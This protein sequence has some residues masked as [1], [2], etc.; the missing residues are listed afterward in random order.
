MACCE[1]DTDTTNLSDASLLERY[2]RRILF[3]VTDYDTPRPPDDTHV[4]YTTLAAATNSTLLRR[5]NHN[6]HSRDHPLRIRAEILVEHTL[7]LTAETA[8]AMRT[9]ATREEDSIYTHYEGWLPEDDDLPTTKWAN[10]WTP[11]MR[12]SYPQATPRFTPPAPIALPLYDPDDPGTR[13]RL[14]LLGRT[15]ARP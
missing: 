1:P 9:A 12:D 8:T 13:A 4:P 2:E 5:R 14:T 15:A 6:A 3:G 7:R 11:L 10:Q